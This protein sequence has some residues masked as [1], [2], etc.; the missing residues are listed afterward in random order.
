[1]RVV[2]IERAAGPGRGLAGV[3]VHHCAFPELRVEATTALEGVE[4][5]GLR[6]ACARDWA[7][8]EWRRTAL[9]AALGDVEAYLG[10]HAVAV[11]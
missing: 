7:C 11:R 8:D 5:L 1:M 10:G 3:L 9:R 2:V 4:R 6:I